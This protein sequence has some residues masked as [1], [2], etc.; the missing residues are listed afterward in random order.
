M[1]LKE[2]LQTNNI[3][4]DYNYYGLSDMATYFELD[5]LLSKLPIVFD[6]LDNFSLSELSSFEDLKDFFLVNKISQFSELKDKVKP[7][8]RQDFEHLLEKANSIP[9]VLDSKFPQSPIC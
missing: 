9:L 6:F 5:S 8:Y 7:D 3:S 1:S 2:T 4:I